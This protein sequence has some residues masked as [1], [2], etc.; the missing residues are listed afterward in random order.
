MVLPDWPHQMP[1]RLAA[2][3]CGYVNEE[4]KPQVDV[5]RARVDAGKLPEGRMDGKRLF[6]R[7]ADLEHALDAPYGTAPALPAIDPYVEALRDA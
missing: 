3:F 5:F 6:W 1:I 7:K 2:A 4:G